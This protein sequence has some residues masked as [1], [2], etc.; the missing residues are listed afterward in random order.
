MP[1]TYLIKDKSFDL[2]VIKVVKHLESMLNST[3]R[4]LSFVQPL[5]FCDSTSPSCCKNGS[6]MGSTIF[7]MYIVLFN[8]LFTNTKV[9]IYSTPYHDAK[10]WAS[11]LYAYTLWKRSLPMIQTTI[12]T[13]EDDYSS[14]L[15]SCS[16]SV[17]I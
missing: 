10:G 16:N 14:R 11:V 3:S 7:L 1:Y 12:Y 4:H 17:A 13:T 5:D 8:V 15:P 9:V 2:T 6:R